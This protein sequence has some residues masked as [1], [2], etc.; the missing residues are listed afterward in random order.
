MTSV[1]IYSVENNKN[2][3]KTL[4]EKACPNF[5]L[6]LYIYLSVRYILNI[7]GTWL[8]SQTAL[9]SVSPSIFG[10]CGAGGW[11]MISIYI[12]YELIHA[13]LHPPRTPIPHTGLLLFLRP[14]NLPRGVGINL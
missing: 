6:V 11:Q 5:C 1:L 9:S 12:S 14:S 7:F 2:E 10:D 8:Y 13:C 3:E 4:S